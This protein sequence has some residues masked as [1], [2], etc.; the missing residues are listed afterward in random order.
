MPTAQATAARKRY[1]LVIRRLR[2]EDGKLV[3]YLPTVQLAELIGRTPKTING[4]ARVGLVRSPGLLASHRHCSVA[5]AT[6]VRRMTQAERRELG[7]LVT[8]EVERLK[9]RRLFE[10][11]Q[12]DTLPRASH[13]LEHYDDYDLAFII[14]CVEEGRA[15][16]TIAK[17]LGRSY[18]GICNVVGHLRQAGDLPPAHEGEELDWYSQVLL[19]LTP[20]EV[21]SLR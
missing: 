10:R 3:T 21:E 4:W 17:A 19:L 7:I 9:S 15:F 18:S 13:R 8:P 16:D 5:D 20:D 12:R 2:D 11:K 14:S 1:G 6:R